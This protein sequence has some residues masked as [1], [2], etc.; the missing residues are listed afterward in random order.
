[1]K[2]IFSILPFHSDFIKMSFKGFPYA[3]LNNRFFLSKQ[4]KK[5]MCIYFEILRFYLY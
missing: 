4:K 5:M 1:M 3:A 2:I